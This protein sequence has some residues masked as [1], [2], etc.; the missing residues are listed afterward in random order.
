M[1][2]PVRVLHIITGLGS[3]GAEMML[4]KLLG[5]M[6]RERFD[7][8][9]I[10]LTDEGSMGARIRSL[11]VPVHALGMKRG[12]P[13]P[14]AWLRLVGMIRREKVQLVQCWMYH[15]DLLGGLAARAAG[16]PV[17]WSLRQSNLAPEL[18]RRTTLMIVK[19]CARLSTLIPR[20]IVCGSNAARRAHVDVGYA[21]TGMVTIPNGFDME[22]FS[23]SNES[24][25]AMRAA[26]GLETADAPL[27]GLAARFD[28][29]KDHANFIAAA[30]MLHQRMPEARFVMCGDGVTWDNS[31]LAERIAQAAV[32][33]RCYL[34]GRRDDVPTLLAALDVACSSSRGEGFANVIGEAMACG[35]P[36]VVTDVGDSA[37][38]VGDTG[39]VVPPGD[40]AALANGLFELLILSAQER[41]RLGEAARRRIETNFSLPAVAARYEAL[42][43][44]VLAQCAA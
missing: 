32:G 4:Y 16:V 20:Y 37:A 25:S 2:T 26:L 1:P 41:R 42:Y 22:L 6:D 34:L 15:A 10:S 38:I 40:P 5:A 12:M 39:R 33:D 23:P 31:F 13:N 18:N 9:V 17:I 7:S 21:D 30:G 28:P 19:A 24:R 3:G 14:W 8:L 29:Q 43:Q 27:I 35:V 36:C 44:E 11:G